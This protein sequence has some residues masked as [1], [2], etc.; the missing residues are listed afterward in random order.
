MKKMLSLGLL[1]TVMTGASALADRDFTY[2]G[3]DYGYDD[4]QYRFSDRDLGVRYR[5]KYKDPALCA[6]LGKDVQVA[7]GIFEDSL[8]R[9]RS[10]RSDADAANSELSSRKNELYRA[11]QAALSASARLTNLQNTQARFDELMSQYQSELSDAIE[12]QASAKQ[13][14]DRAQAKEDS[15]C[16]GWGGLRS[17]C[18]KAR[19]ANEEAG[20][21]L[22]NANS[23]LS[24]AQSNVDRLNRLP[25]DLDAAQRQVTATSQTLSTVQAKTPTISELQS[26]ADSAN[27]AYSSVRANFDADEDNY[28][29][30]AVRFEQCRRMAFESRKGRAYQTALRRL[31]KTKGNN[32]EEV[33]RRLMRSTRGRYAA[34]VGIDQAYQDYCATDLLVRFV[35]VP[36]AQDN[37]PA[38]AH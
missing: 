21:A 34:Q 26:I 5:R 13:A 20:E 8:S 10:F 37:T 2:Y 31:A 11:E 7:R 19:R 25:S 18:R 15:E 22:N 32:C 33:Y 14:K 29:R 35:E 24:A 38:F 28:G 17:P 27:S 4:I 6:D 16:N 3:D 30:K 12:V 9:M 36:A 23:A 1:M